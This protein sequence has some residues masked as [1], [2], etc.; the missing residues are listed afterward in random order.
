MPQA[1]QVTYA[2]SNE[3]ALTQ[4]VGLFKDQGWKVFSLPEVSNESALTQAVGE[5]FASIVMEDEL[6]PMS[7]H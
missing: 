4:A 5:V 7:P 3:S 1:D 6:F 2:V